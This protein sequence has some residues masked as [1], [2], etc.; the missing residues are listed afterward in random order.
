M[1]MPTPLL[2]GQC[3]NIWSHSCPQTTV[4][5]LEFAARSSYRCLPIYH[6]PVRTSPYLITTNVPCLIEREARPAVHFLKWIVRAH[7][8]FSMPSSLPSFLLHLRLSYISDDNHTFCS[9]DGLRNE[10][11]GLSSTALDKAL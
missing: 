5:Q 1:L 4:H 8:E 7:R 10:V 3:Q 2:V 6:R 11:I 9:P